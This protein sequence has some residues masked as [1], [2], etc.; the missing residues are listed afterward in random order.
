[1]ILDVERMAVKLWQMTTGNQATAER[2]LDTMH[3]AE[4]ILLGTTET[5]TEAGHHY[6][7]LLLAPLRH[8]YRQVIERSI[9]YLHPDHQN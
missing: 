5:V 4:T 6:P 3:H 8:P 2:I 1:M 9:D 7:I